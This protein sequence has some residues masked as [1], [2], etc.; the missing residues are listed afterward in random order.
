MNKNLFTMFTGLSV[1]LALSKK[2]S[3]PPGDFCN[4]QVAVPARRAQYIPGWNVTCHEC[5][6]REPN[7]NNFCKGEYCYREYSTGNQMCGYGSPM[8]THSYRTIGTLGVFFDVKSLFDFRSIQQCLPRSVRD[9]CRRLAVEKRVCV[10]SAR[11]Q[12]VQ[13]ERATVKWTESHLDSLSLQPTLSH[14]LRYYRPRRLS[15]T[16]KTNTPLYLLLVPEPRLRPNPT[17]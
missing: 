5:T 3:H 7:C 16:E 8:L 13:H 1:L 9:D 4:Q 2:H 6:N 12:Q 11:L 15:A 14:R 17:H 10:Q